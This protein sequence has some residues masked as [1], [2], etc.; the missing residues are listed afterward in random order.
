MDF[1][2]HLGN[3]DQEGAPSDCRV[4][5]RRVRREAQRQNGG[6]ELSPV[7]PFFILSEDEPYGR[8]ARWMQ[9][10]GER[11]GQESYR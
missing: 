6:T 10:G 4:L 1:S 2:C 9:S 3:G 11:A 7:L 8:R 5:V